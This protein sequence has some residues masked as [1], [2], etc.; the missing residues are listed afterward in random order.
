VIDAVVRLYLPLAG[1][2]HLATGSS[3]GRGNHADHSD[4]FTLDDLVAAQPGGDCAQTI[5][6]DRAT[7]PARRSSSEVDEL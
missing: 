7:G 2:T 5:D 6:L 3:P 4:H 1:A